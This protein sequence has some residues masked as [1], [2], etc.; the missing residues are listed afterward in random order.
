VPVELEVVSGVL[1]VAAHGELEGVSVELGFV[2][3]L[4][5][6]LLT[7]TWKMMMM[8]LLLSLRLAYYLK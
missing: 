3:A 4:Q 6:L 8:A 1:S 7:L 5:L 2:P